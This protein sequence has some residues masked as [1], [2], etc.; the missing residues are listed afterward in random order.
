MASSAARGKK[1]LEDSRYNDAIIEFTAALKEFPD[2]PDYLIQRSTAYLRAKNNAESLLDAERAVLNAQK[3]AKREFIIEAQFRRGCAL[4]GLERYGDAEYLFALVK[5]MKSDHKMC[6]MWINKTK[7]ALAKLPADDE[8]RQQTVK[9]TPEAVEEH[10]T[11][12]TPVKPVATK[13][14]GKVESTAPVLPQQTPADKIKWD[15]YQNTENVYFTLSVKGA[16]KDKVQVNIQDR[17]LNITF[18]LVSGADY[19]LTLDPLFAEVKPAAC[20]TRVLAM[21]IEVILVKATPGI[22]WSAIEGKIEPVSNPAIDTSTPGE[23]ADAAKGAGLNDNKPAGPPAYPTS[24][25]SGPKNWDKITSD[26]RKTDAQGQEGT[27]EADE[28]YEGGDPANHFFKKLFKDA[29]P[30]VQRAMMKSYTESNGTALS[31]NWDEVSKG[32]VETTPP[33]GMEARKW[34]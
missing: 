30:D 4:Y 10:A 15:W 19:D 5:K 7:M 29:S 21:K 20:V 1:A 6:D 9:E 26:L 34:G 14:V 18:P 23:E 33:D 32:P 3:R 27:A 12:G 24:S 2:S 13:D 11:T 31:T 22:K 25:K 8:K 17:T 16:P 28:D